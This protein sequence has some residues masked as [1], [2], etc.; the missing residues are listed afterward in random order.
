M[1]SWCKSFFQHI[2]GTIRQKSEWTSSS[3]ARA[4]YVRSPAIFFESV[5]EIVFWLVVSTHLK[6]YSSEMGIFTNFRD[7]NKKCLSCHHL[8]L[9]G[10]NSRH[11]GWIPRRPETWRVPVVGPG[12]ANVTRAVP[13]ASR[14]RD[15][16]AGF[17]GFCMHLRNRETTTSFAVRTVSSILTSQLPSWT[18]VLKC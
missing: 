13:D 16:S 5:P 12:Y 10:G 18:S 17:A 8:V 3:M 11:V 1:A 14:M 9:L 7:E 6:K 2:T 15:T 4:W